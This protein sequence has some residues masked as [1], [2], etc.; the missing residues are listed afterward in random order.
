MSNLFLSFYKN[1]SCLVAHIFY[2]G[3]V[4]F[5][6]RSQISELPHIL[7]EFSGWIVHLRWAQPKTKHL[8]Q[9]GP[10]MMALLICIHKCTLQMQKNRCV[11]NRFCPCKRPALVTHAGSNTSV[12]VDVYVLVKA[13]QLRPFT[14][15]DVM[16]PLYCWRST[17]LYHPNDWKPNALTKKQ[18]FSC[19][20]VSHA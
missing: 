3:L 18:I 1:K 7:W 6:Y 16:P 14:C 5:Q 17:G 9:V 20:F 4:V 15:F 11:I 13:V 8:K 2:L 12:D 19:F 10:A